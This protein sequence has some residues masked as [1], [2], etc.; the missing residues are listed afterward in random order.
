MRFR[1]CLVAMVVGVFGFGATGLAQAP[2]TGTERLGWDQASPDL[3]TA[4]AYHADVEVDSVVASSNVAITCSG[5]ASP[6]T[7]SAAFPSMTLGPHAVRIRVIQTVS[8]EPFTSAWSAPFSVL[9]LV[10]PPTP[11]NLRVIRSGG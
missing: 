3:A 8:G 10:G 5:A 2:A 4:Q 11:L 9:I 6:F 7:C 1:T